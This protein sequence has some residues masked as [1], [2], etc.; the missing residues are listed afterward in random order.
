MPAQLTPQDIEALAHDGLSA[1]VD[2]KTI[3]ALALFDDMAALTGLAAE[4]CIGEYGRQMT[5]SKKVFIP[6][7]TL[8]RDVCHY[9]TFAKAPSPG[10]PA[11]MSIDEVM[12]VA[13]AGRLAGCKEALLTL[14][15]KPELRYAAAREALA[16]QSCET[17]F[18][19]LERCADIVL[20]QT[21]LLPH[22]NAGVMDEATAAKFRRVSASQG[23]MLE[24]LS[25]RLCAKGGAHYGSPDKMPDVRL[26]ALRA[27][28][29][30]SVPMTTGLLIGIGETRFERLEALLA[31]GALHAEFGHIQEVIVQN[32]RAKPGTKMANAPEPDLGDHLW[33][34]ATARI[35][36]APEI[37]LQAPPNLRAGEAGQLI[38]AGINDWGGISPITIDHVNPEA[39]WPQIDTLTDICESEGRFLAERLAIYPRQLEQPDRWLD[40]RVIP[41]VL[42]LQDSSGLAREDHWMS[43][44]AL[45]PPPGVLL[46]GRRTKVSFDESDGIYRALEKA[47]CGKR[48]GED[49]IVALFA[50]RGEAYHGVCAI[51][52]RLR[53]KTNGDAVTY[54]INRNINYTNICTY[55]CQFCAFSKGRLSAGLRETPYNLALGEISERMRE[56]EMRGATE[57]CLQGGIAPGYSGKTYLDILRTV[58]RAAP[59]IHVHAFSPLEIWHGSK[60]L[61]LPL[62]D[63]LAMLKDEG[64]GSL[65][66]TAAEILD[67]DVRAVLC[68][69]KINTRQWLDVMRVAHQ[70]GLPSTATIMFGHVDHPRHWARHLLHVRALQEVTGG[71]TEFVPLPF[72]A[73]EAPIYLKGR[74]RS[75]PTF[76]EAVLMHAVARIA[77]HPLVP[78]I[79]TSWVKMG[80]DGAAA[81]LNAGANDFGGVLMNE[82]ITRAAGAAFGQEFSAEKMIGVIQKAGRTALE[83]TTLYKPVANQTPGRRFMTAVE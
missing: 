47:E 79:Q 29:R 37:S 36:L 78:N 24:S 12:T 48:L 68:P 32:F 64:L 2:P 3:E 26:E 30:A 57:V 49:Q 76:R 18:D 69:D 40:K 31:I 58:K 20:R 62:A 54:V 11:Y 63:Y 81:C 33:T 16:G 19:Y 27:A 46:P 28:G 25:E 73:M 66:G 82:S 61:G 70:A 56:A 4:I 53:H 6:L 77:L 22:L 9:C 71:F 72:V 17:T 45:T 50:A 23:L 10:M 1:A 67:D 21:G 59:G 44:S 65:P 55:G 51:A 38:C 52:D 80:P 39:P 74:A 42:K 14:G 83:R 8:C 41:Y 5:F 15:D 34:I 13:E 60:T 75:G 35:L 43:G 7:T